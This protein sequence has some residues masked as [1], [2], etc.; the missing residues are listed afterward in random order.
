MIKFKTLKN[1]EYPKEHI[2]GDYGFNVNA[3]TL[4]KEAIKWIKHLEH[5]H[6]QDF[7]DKIDLTNWIKHFFNLTEEDLK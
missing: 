4:R 5:V 1:I 2:I 6:K 3:D 7:Y